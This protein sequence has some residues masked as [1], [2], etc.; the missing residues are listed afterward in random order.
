M[1]TFIRF[2]ENHFIQV[3]ESYKEVKN[4]IRYSTN[5]DYWIELTKI[6]RN[7]WVNIESLIS[8]NSRTIQSYY[9]RN[10]VNKLEGR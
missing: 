8:I 4:L 9:S 6:E 2:S 5:D 7:N 3:K 1:S 10:N